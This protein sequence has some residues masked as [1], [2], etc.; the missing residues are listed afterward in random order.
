MKY[1]GL[2]FVKCDL[3][4]HSPASH[5]YPD[6]NISAEDFIQAAI[7][8]DLRVIAI[9]DHNSGE[10]INQAQKAAVGT[11]LIILPGVEISCV[12]GKYG[13]HIIALFDKNKDD[14]TINAL[15]SKVEILPDDYGQKTAFSKKSVHEVIDIIGEMGGL[16][17][18][19]HCTSTKGVLSE[20]GGINR[21]EV[22]R[23]PWLLAVES[24]TNDYNSEEKK[25]NHKRAYDLL[26]GTD[27]NYNKR[28]LAV[29]SVSDAHS[30]NDMGKYHSYFKVDTDDISLESI[31]QCFIDREV[32]IL[33]MS[34]YSLPL[35]PY[36]KSISIESGFFD[37]ETAEFHSGLNTIIGA[38]GSGKSL[39][40][41]LMRFGLNNVPIDQ[42][43]RADHQSKLKLQ[44]QDYGK[45]HMNLVSDLQ[46][47]ANITRTYNVASSEYMNELDEITASTFP[48]L[49]LSQNEIIRIAEDPD[50]QMKFIDSFFDFKNYITQINT[51]REDLTAL[52]RR[53][54]RSLKASVNITDVDKTLGIYKQQ[55]EKIEKQIT[56]PEYIKFKKE[57]V[58]NN[59]ILNAKKTYDR[60][61]E[62][63]EE[64]SNKI[65]RSYNLEIDSSISDNPEIKRINDLLSTAKDT[66]RSIL[67][68]ALDSL[69]SSSVSFEEEYSQWVKKYS[70]AQAKYD[71]FVGENGAQQ[72][73]EKERS[74]LVKTIQ[75]F[76]DKL[77]KESES[78]ELLKNINNE[79]NTKLDELDSIYKEFLKERQEKCRVFENAS[80]GKLKI[81]L[82]ESSNNDIFREALTNLKKGSYLRDSDIVAIC[83]AFSAREFIMNLLYYH[84]DKPDRKQR[85]VTK[86]A[87][88]SKLAIDTMR[89]LFDFLLS[90]NE[91][92]NILKLQYDAR[93]Q[94][95]PEINVLVDGK[96][97]NIQYVSV[98]QKCNAMLIIALSDGLYPVIIDQPEDSLDIRSIWDDICMR[99]RHNKIGRQFI[100]TTHNSSLA[101][102]SD[103]D[104]YTIIECVDGK[105]KITSTGAIGS[106]T[107]KH[108]VIDYLEGGSKTYLSKY[109][110][111][112][113]NLN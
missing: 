91:L 105:G 5:D 19:A 113:F 15:L 97:Q 74:K 25:K 18:L 36:I 108:G 33:Q 111:Y 69:S 43:V 41:E 99:I 75:S 87:E 47:E 50:K 46:K 89:R 48:V 3:H 22:F 112:G 38:K 66:C 68:K 51:I 61:C 95:R 58:L 42:S 26:D 32:R 12:G 24:S 27:P 100:F 82:H 70:K 20:L 40:V 78:A 88:K 11:G 92:E 57:E 29:Y 90:E 86:T 102:A 110:K 6:K 62:D 71:K 64:F 106:T 16:P 28:K 9:T 79:R 7:D 30:L 85:W 31:R 23:S 73:L 93:S 77:S 35:P 60:L 80:A 4:V 34:E 104:K 101:V 96:H 76:S 10:F 17:V 52:D 8:K 44:L 84:T 72:E 1:K 54:A 94:D 59:T 107:I 56:S 65:A 109:Q 39:L 53:F 83:S 55:L 21:E 45:I 2:S 37:G 63:F 49:F 98:G 103:T 81:T 13:I 14:K 67:S